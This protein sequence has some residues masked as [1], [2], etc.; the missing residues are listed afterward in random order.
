MALVANIVG[1]VGG[2][3]EAGMTVMSGGI[4]AAFAVS[5]GDCVSA[6]F[7]KLGN[8]DIRFA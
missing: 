8:V 6:R 7:Q 5:P 1:S 3:L 4:T 2:R